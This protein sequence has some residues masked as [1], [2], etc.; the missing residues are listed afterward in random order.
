MFHCVAKIREDS[1]KDLLIHQDNC[2]LLLINVE[3]P[4]QY[5]YLRDLK[6]KPCHQ[7]LK[8]IFGDNNIHSFPCM[9]GKRWEPSFYT[10]APLSNTMV[11]SIFQI[12]SW[13][14]VH[15][16]PHGQCNKWIPKSSMVWPS[17]HRERCEIVG[18]G[19]LRQKVIRRW[20]KDKWNEGVLERTNNEA[21]ATRPTLE[22]RR[23]HT[24]SKGTY[25][26]REVNS[27]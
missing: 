12:M 16:F 22:Q 9:V 7:C 13:A 10:W 18:C 6:K 3:Y 21:L 17:W 2:H 1:K 4:H 27:Y 26:K 8:T 14:A 20:A 11:T 24:M 23:V 25:V 5:T 15:S 19:I